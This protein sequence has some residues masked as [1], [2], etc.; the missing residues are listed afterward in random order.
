ME[1]AQGLGCGGGKEGV[2]GLV[3]KGNMEGAQGLECG[4]GSYGRCM[5]FSGEKGGMGG[6]GGYNVTS[7]Y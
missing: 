3:G 4:G 7:P 2:Q 5:V 1:G 6:A